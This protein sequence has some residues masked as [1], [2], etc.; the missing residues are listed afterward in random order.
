M[1]SAHSYAPRM[2]NLDSPGY[3]L[4]MEAWQLVHFL[5]VVD[6]KSCNAKGLYERG[7]VHSMMA[8]VARV[9]KEYA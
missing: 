6:V 5:P 7:M 1:E 8:L 4:V 2:E 9:R 3:S